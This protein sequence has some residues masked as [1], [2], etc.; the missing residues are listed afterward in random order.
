M[1]AMTL[2]CPFTCVQIMLFA[3]LISATDTV[4]VLAIFSEVRFIE[5]H[6]PLCNVPSLLGVVWLFLHTSHKLHFTQFLIYV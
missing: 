4:A 6:Y 2:N 5:I 3:S 1:P